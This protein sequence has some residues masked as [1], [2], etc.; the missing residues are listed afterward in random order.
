LLASTIDDIEFELSQAS[1]T[2]IVVSVRGEPEF[3][4]RSTRLAGPAWCQD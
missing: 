2:C 1:Q 3:Y 4:E